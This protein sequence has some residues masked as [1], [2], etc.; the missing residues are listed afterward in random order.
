[1]GFNSGFKGL[2]VVRVEVHELKQMDKSTS[3]MCD[4][5]IQLVQITYSKGTNN[6][7][8][9]IRINYVI[10]RNSEKKVVSGT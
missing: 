5:F 3:L 6:I 4:D 10:L 8:R 7:L 1:M 9:Y 2:T